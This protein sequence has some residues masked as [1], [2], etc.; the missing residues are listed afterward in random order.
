MA[1]I[2][3]VRKAPSCTDPM[4][5]KHIVTLAVVI[6]LGVAMEAWLMVAPPSH[7][8]PHPSYLPAE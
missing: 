8:P 4:T 5:L 6:L 7:P 1:K 2:S 3:P